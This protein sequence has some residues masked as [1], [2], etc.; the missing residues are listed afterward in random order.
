MEVSFVLPSYAD[1]SF[2][3]SM[4][5]LGLTVLSLALITRSGHESYD[6][7]PMIYFVLLA[8]AVSGV[9]GAWGRI[10][11]VDEQIDRWTRIVLIAL[12]VFVIGAL[13]NILWRSWKSGV[14]A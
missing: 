8:L 13:L 5:I 10:V 4:V 11:G 12:R 14:D 6:W 2:W 7:R 3:L 9:I 1:I